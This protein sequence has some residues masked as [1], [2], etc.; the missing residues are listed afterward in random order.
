[1]YASICMNKWLFCHDEVFCRSVFLKNTLTFKAYTPADY[2]YQG[3]LDNYITHGV[4]EGLTTIKE[5][6]K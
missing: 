3:E 1:M 4:S 6:P 5:P 2:M